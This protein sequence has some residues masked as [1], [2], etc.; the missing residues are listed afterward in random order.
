MLDPIV[1][2][3]DATM[4][5]LRPAGLD[6]RRCICR[7]V[8]GLYASVATL[9]TYTVADGGSD[10]LPWPTIIKALKS[11]ILQ[12]PSLGTIILDS[13]TPR[14]QLAKPDLLDINHHLRVLSSPPIHQDDARDVD[15]FLEDISNE[16]FDRLDVRPPWRLYIR[17]LVT[18][19]SD[20]SSFQ[21]VFACSH[22]IA[23]GR[24]T[25]VFHKAFLAALRQSDKLIALDDK[26]VMNLADI[27]PVLPPMDQAAKFTI[28]WSYLM[29]PFVKEYFPSFIS[30]WLLGEATEYWIGAA[31]RPAKPTPPQL[32]T[33]KLRSRW[34][35]KG[36]IE[37]ALV[38][39]RAH[40]VRL[41]AFLNHMTA[42][43][44]ATVLQKRGQTF[45]QFCVQTAIDLRRA[46]PEY[47]DCMATMAT[48]ATDIITVPP[49]S[50]TSSTSNARLELTEEEWDM[51][52]QSTENLARTSNT[53]DDQV[54]GLLRYLDDFFRWTNQQAEKPSNLS[55]AVSNLGA[56]DTGKD[57]TWTVKDMIFTQSA[58]ATSAPF[59]L[60][61]ANTQGGDLAVV[62]SWWPGMFG[63]P[64][65]DVF[66]E[67]VCFHIEQN[68]TA[69]V[70]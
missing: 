5:V 6:E 37:K 22:S 65:E 27:R 60:N 16:P 4:R 21:A 11:V 54:V 13:H 56:F 34:I 15:S 47:T 8:L 58:D 36:A 32:L 66:A 69:A 46:I 67:D 52:Q 40:N 19:S 14:P 38:L 33:T 2:R 55:F 23:D 51:M 17:P 3:I 43:A 49:E 62:V 61:I 45:D 25:Y 28:S 26:P 42:R 59:N 7:D 10:S 64:D 1:P 35:A 53:L 24:S 20:S 50:N 44:L 9:A 41:T 39:C 70:R 31:T 63:V 48:A 29:R 18:D 30:S 68:V 57:T 12:H